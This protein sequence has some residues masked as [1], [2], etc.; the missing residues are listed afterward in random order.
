MFQCKCLPSIHR[1]AD[2]GADEVVGMFASEENH[3]ALSI[4]APASHVS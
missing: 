1:T 4:D 2:P 3:E